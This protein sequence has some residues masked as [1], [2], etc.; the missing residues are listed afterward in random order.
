MM[1]GLC[2]YNI[3]L[4]V[5]IKNNTTVLFNL[6]EKNSSRNKGAGIKRI[7]TVGSGSVWVEK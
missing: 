7:S 2:F 3:L 1:C 6:L 4:S 5:R